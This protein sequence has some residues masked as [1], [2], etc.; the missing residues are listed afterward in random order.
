ATGEAPDSLPSIPVGA[1]GEPP[2]SAIAASPLVPLRA[3]A[4]PLPAGPAPLVGSP[5]TAGSPAA[6]RAPVN[7][8][9]DPVPV[10]RAT[11]DPPAKTKPLVTVDELAGKEPGNAPAAKK[12]T[13]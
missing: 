6:D 13:A 2:E 10:Q 7:Q 8:P 4:A 5:L 11:D 9:A 3:P 12:P 1:T